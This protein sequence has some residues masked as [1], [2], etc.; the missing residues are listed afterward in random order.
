MTDLNQLTGSDK[1]D[2]IRRVARVLQIIQYIVARPG[3]WSRKALASQCEISE[4]QIQKDLDIIRYKLN[5]SLQHDGK[6][7]C[8]ERVPRLPTIAYT[9]A[10]ALALLLAFQA[11]QQIS[12]INSPDLA[13]AIARLQSV[14]PP[15]FLPLFN[16][17][18]RQTLSST[19]GDHRQQA[20]ALLNHALSTRRK[21]QIVYRTHSRGGEVNQ[22]VIHP[23]YIQLHVRSWH[24][25]AYCEKRQDVLVFK[26]DRIDALDLLEERYVIPATFDLKSYIGDTWGWMRGDAGEPV[27][28]VVQFDAVAGPWVAEEQWHPNQRFEK[29]EDGSVLLRAHIGVTAEFV[30]WLLYYGARV[31]VL[32]PAWLRERVREE[33]RKALEV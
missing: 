24:V 25:I 13:A 3:Y 5:F 31:K 21:V 33:H 12:G 15:E 14:F 19:Q 27:D 32:E 26:V 30:N 1:P 20:L 22:R 2:E 11:A 18:S 29:Q 6:G 8:F 9:F 10:E 28:V 7:Y 17:I 23:Y 16:Q 4:R